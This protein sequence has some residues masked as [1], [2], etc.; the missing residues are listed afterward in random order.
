[1]HPPKKFCSNF[2][3]PVRA[4]GR[5]WSG[6]FQVNFPT[7][8]RGRA[9]DR[10]GALEVLAGGPGDSRPVALGP[11]RGSS[12]H[13]PAQ[14]A[15]GVPSGLAAARPRAMAN[16]AGCHPS[17]GGRGESLAASCAAARGGGEGRRA[18]AGA[19]HRTP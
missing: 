17:A 18:C 1:M 19:G 11:R 8:A 12:G 3:R 4:P 16:L 10:G 6:R 5:N 2:L 13:G 14:A 7:R 9:P 15:Q